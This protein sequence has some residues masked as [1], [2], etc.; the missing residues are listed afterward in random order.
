M[1][2]K[3]KPAG[4]PAGCVPPEENHRAVLPPST[5]YDAPVTNDVLSDARNMMVWAISWGLPTRLSGSVAAPP[6]LSGVPAK[7][8]SIAVS[9][10]PGA[11]RGERAVC[12]ELRTFRQLG[13]GENRKGHRVR[14]HIGLELIWGLAHLLIIYPLRKAYFRMPVEAR[15]QLSETSL[16]TIST[17]EGPWIM[18]PSGLRL[19]T[20]RKVGTTIPSNVTWSKQ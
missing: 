10:G 16:I 12:A 1:R 14:H 3:L 15:P 9:I 13:C 8:F 2:R 7:R 19:T 20:R 5:R 4:L 6:F 11:T 18:A 17:A